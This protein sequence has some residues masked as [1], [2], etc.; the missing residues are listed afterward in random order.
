M[1]F[2][3]RLSFISLLKKLDAGDNET[4]LSAAQEIARRMR[5]AGVDWDDLLVADDPRVEAVTVEPPEESLEDRQVILAILRHEEIA[6]ETRLEL[7][8]FLDDIDKG[9]FT[10]LDG[11][12]V[13]ALYRRLYADE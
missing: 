4:V 7:Q 1:P 9:R 2:P 10:E 8:Q 11:A 3:D 5:D 6:T 12:Y 13:R